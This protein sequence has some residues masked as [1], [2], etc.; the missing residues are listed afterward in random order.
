M[1]MIMM[2]DLDIKVAGSG[3][4]HGQKSKWDN[5]QWLRVLGY[6]R[7]TRKIS[8]EAL[9]KLAQRKAMRS[10]RSGHADMA[11][12]GEFSSQI[13]LP[14]TTGRDEP[15]CRGTIRNFFEVRTKAFSESTS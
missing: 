14:Q 9:H 13:P 12:V 3:N 6:S 8:R 5:S 11:K 2:F 1:L 7:K 10:L 4:G 15:Q